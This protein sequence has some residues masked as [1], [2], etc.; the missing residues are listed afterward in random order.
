MIKYG[1]I[2]KKDPE[3]REQKIKIYYDENNVPTGALITYFLPESVQQA[4]SFADG[5]DIRPGVPVKVE[6]AKFDQN[7]SDPSKKR[8]RK[9]KKVYDQRK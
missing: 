3:T 9:P 1:G 4:L 8:R 6:E 7:K 5:N 2:I